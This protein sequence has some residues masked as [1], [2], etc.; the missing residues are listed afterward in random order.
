MWAVHLK[1][2]YNEA[3]VAS[4]VA[5]HVAEIS[6]GFGGNPATQISIGSATADSSV[7]QVKKCAVVCLVCGGVAS[8]WHSRID[9]QPLF[10]STI[11]LIRA[12][13]TLL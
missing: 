1:Q 11:R 13:W 8:E 12:P 5:S 3:T 6:I 7:E 9:S 2:E 10:F 4:S